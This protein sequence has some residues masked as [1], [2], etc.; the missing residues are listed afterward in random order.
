MT[1][2]TTRLP[3]SKTEM[4]GQITYTR[5][6]MRQA[7]VMAEF[8]KWDDAVDYLQNAITQLSFVRSQAEKNIESLADDKVGA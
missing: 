7:M 5:E 4:R 1:K 2:K 6:Q 8:G 3:M